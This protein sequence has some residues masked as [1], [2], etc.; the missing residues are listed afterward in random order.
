MKTDISIIT[1]V[2]ENQSLIYLI[3]KDTDLDDLPVNEKERDFVKAQIEL[4]EK[5]IMINLYNR[6]IYFQVVEGKNEGNH[7]LEWLRIA[8][9]KLHKSIISNKIKTV[10]LVDTTQERE[11]ILALAEG[12]ALSNY[13]FLKYFKESKEKQYSLKKLQIYSTSVSKKDIVYLQNLINAVYYARTL[14]NEPAS[15]LTAERLSEEIRDI[16][17]EAGFSV[18]VLHKRKIMSLKMGGLLAVNKG[19][20]DPPTFSILEWKPQN[21]INKKPVILVGKGVVFDTGGL[22]L[23]PTKDSMDYMKSDMSGAAAVTGALFATAKSKLPVHVIGLIPA[24]DNRPDGNA[25]A[26]GDVVTMGNGLTVEVL[27]TDAEGR[28]ILAEA[29]NYAKLFKPELIINLATLTGSAAI[30]IGKYGIVGMGNA[31]TDIFGILK[32][33]SE[34]VCERIVEFPFWEEYDEQL[35]SDI[36]DLKNIGGKEAGAIIAGKFLEHFTEFPFIH[37]DIAGPAFVQKEYNY[38]GT[39][40]TGYSVRLIFDFLKNYPKS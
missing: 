32:K 24:T 19:S 31:N 25:Y 35:K 13:Q 14:I 10:N 23:K 29:L 30:A 36:A 18:N 40:G 27:N 9:Y 20:V 38:R 37:L 8:G 15:V 1:K 6:W 4:E 16:G 7:L 33:S 12:I 39:G 11:W 26:P 3:K 17:Q 5:L 28:M 2:I 22:S 34:K 21:A